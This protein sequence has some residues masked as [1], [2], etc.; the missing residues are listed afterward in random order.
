LISISQGNSVNF[1]INLEENSANFS[2][3]HRE[4]S[5]QVVRWTLHK[6]CVWEA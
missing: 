3:D 2:I 4:I 1:L 5:V 6:V